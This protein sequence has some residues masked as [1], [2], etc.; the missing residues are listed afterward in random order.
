V[1]ETSIYRSID[2][3]PDAETYPGLLIVRFDGALF[4]ANAH[5]FVTA[6]RTAIAAADPPP[7]VVVIDGESMNDID[8]TAI[9]TM[10]EFH[11]QLRQTGIQLRFARIKSQIME[12]MDR[13]GLEK[14]VPAEH[15]Y[16]S[17]QAAVDAYLAEEE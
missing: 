15:F 14:T 5:D 9:I 16:P 10:R 4:F 11:T 8:A 1:P 13:G 12:V 3:Y 2:H 6:V 17:I 7:R